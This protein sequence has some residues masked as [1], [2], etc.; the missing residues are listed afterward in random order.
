MTTVHWIGFIENLSCRWFGG[1]MEQS[2]SRTAKATPASTVKQPRLIDL[3]EDGEN[4]LVCIELP[5]V[6]SSDVAVSMHDGSLVIR[7]ES[8]LD[9]GRI[10]PKLRELREDVF[11][12]A[13]YLYLRNLISL[14]GHNI[15]QACQLSGLSRSRL[16]TLLKKYQLTSP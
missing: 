3:S 4:L 9:R 2:R 1:I 11:F 10:L 5:G 7:R 16:Y 15:R 6:K 12:R 8:Q 14:T 13:E